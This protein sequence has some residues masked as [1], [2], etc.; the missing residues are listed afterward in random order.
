MKLNEKIRRRKEY[1]LKILDELRQQAELNPDL[2][3]V[4]LLWSVGIIRRAGMG[5]HDNFFEESVD[6]YNLISSDN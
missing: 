3:F 6:T 5:I 1:N 2:R 4:Q